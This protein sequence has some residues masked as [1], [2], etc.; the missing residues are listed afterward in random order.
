M[1]FNGSNGYFLI[2]K[3]TAFG[4]KPTTPKAMNLSNSLYGESITSTAE[5][6][7]S[8]VISNKK[9]IQAVRNG[10]RSI[11]GD[12][13]FE[14]SVNNMSLI[15]L[16]AMGSYTQTNETINGVAKKKKVFK[17][18]GSIPSFLL[19]KNI[20]GGSAFTFLGNKVNTLSAEFASDAMVSGSIGI[21]GKSMERNNTPFDSNPISQTHKPYAG[22]DTMIEY[23]GV[24]A[25]F[26]SLSFSLENELTDSRCI[27]N[28][29]RSQ[30]G[31]GSGNVTLN[32]VVVYSNNDF[33]DDFNNETEVP[34]K[35]TMTLD[36]DYIQINVP[37]A[38]IIENEPIPQFND[39][40]LIKLDI[41]LQAL[42]SKT[43]STD[44][45]ITVVDDFDLDDFLS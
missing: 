20:D 14:M 6:L 30:I 8:E 12:I 18:A 19:E 23:N 37:R 40:G 43:D 35:L 17:R 24:G 4:V 41:S 22:I 1:A 29:Y 21:M 39:S 9:G 3:E 27:G 45:I 10:T 5:V 13:P 11:D 25:C 42:L 28:K 34:V 7:R 15:L 33:Q 32:F 44:L 31:D 38:K 26:E 2:Q 16:L 36:N